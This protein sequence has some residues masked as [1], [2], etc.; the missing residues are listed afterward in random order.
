MRSGRLSGGRRR[1]AR[2]RSRQAVA[3][4]IRESI[5][6]ESI[7]KVQAIGHINAYF[8][9][10]DRTD[11]FSL[12]EAIRNARSLWDQSLVWPEMEY[13]QVRNGLGRVVYTYPELDMFAV[14]WKKEGF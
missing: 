5:P 10:R 2:E 14:N 7:Y 6:P 8:L 3:A 4:R 12:S 13:V 1:R 11:Y 9:P